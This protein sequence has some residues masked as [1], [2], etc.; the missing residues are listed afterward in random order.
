MK[1]EATPQEVA[2]LIME[3]SK[4]A[5]KEKSSVA[6]TTRHDYCRSAESACSAAKPSESWA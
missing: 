1:L 6:I 4:T 5:S 2:E 3:L